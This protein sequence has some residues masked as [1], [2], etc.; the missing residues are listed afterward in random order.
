MKGEHYLREDANTVVIGTTTTTA[1]V[2]T[3]V[4]LKISWQFDETLDLLENLM[5]LFVMFIIVKR[6]NLRSV[7]LT[8]QAIS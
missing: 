2:E 7:Y 5:D 1:V 3:K 8:F 6:N 4:D